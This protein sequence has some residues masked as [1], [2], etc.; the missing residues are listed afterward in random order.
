[1]TTNINLKNVQ[2]LKITGDGTTVLAD[3]GTYIDVKGTIEGTLNTFPT[4]GKSGVLYVDTNTNLTYRWSGTVYVEISPSIALGETSSTAYAGDKGKATTDSLNT[5]KA[6]SVSH[7]TS[8]ERTSWNNKIDNTQKGVSNGVAQLDANGL[9]PASQLPSY[10]D[11]VVEGTLG[12]FPTTGETG[13]IYVDT[14]TNLI[15]RWNS[16]TYEDI[17]ND[18]NK[19]K[20]KPTINNV[21]IEG[22]FTLD[23]VTMQMNDKTIATNEW[24]GTKAQYD[25]L[26]TIDPNRVYI[27]TDEYSEASKVES[28]TINGNIKIDGVE[29]KVFNTPTKNMVYTD[30]DSRDT[31]YDSKVTDSNSPFYGVTYVITIKKKT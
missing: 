12:T 8:S 10:V 27:T 14:N 25:A 15:Y 5:H 7:I 11:D 31:S 29:T 26:T 2:I 3:N 28:S 9:V 19:L 13:K 21:P 20:N 22:N 4:T 1:M 17:S 16:T 24:R 18:Y 30:Y 6:D 23:N